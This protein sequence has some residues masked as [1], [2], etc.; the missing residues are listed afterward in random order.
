V[1]VDRKESHASK[2]GGIAPS[3]QP[4]ARHSS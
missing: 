4:V 3:H 2:L 1:S